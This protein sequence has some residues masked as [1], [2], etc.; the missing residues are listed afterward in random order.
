MA[1]DIPECPGQH[2]SA[3][4]NRIN[5]T[6]K[7]QGHS[8]DRVYVIRADGSECY[9]KCSCV[10]L[11]TPIA[12]PG[13]RWRRIQEVMVGDQVMTAEP[14]GH[15]W[16]P[17]TV[18]FSDGTK[19][20]GN[21]VP[22]TI[23]VKTEN[24]IE[25]VVTANHPFLLS[26]GKLQQA[27]R[28]TRSDKLMDENFRPVGI[29]A[30][31]PTQYTGGIWNVS[32]TD[33][34]QPGEPLSNHLI[35]TA[36]II[37][38]DFYAQLYLVEGGLLAAP[39]M[40]TLEYERS[41]GVTSDLQFSSARSRT[42][43]DMSQVLPYKK[44]VPPDGAAPFLPDYMTS[45]VP[46]SLRPLDDTVTLET[47]KY[48][49]WLFK[50]I[51]S[52]VE[53]EVEQHWGDNTVNAYAWQEGGKKHVALLGG[54]IRHR[55]IKAEGLALVTAHEIGHHYGGPP[56]Y[57]NGL[58][59]GG[60]ADYWGAWRAM[61]E[62][63]PGG[64]YF[65]QM[66][67]AIDQLDDLFSNG[68]LMGAS[69]AHQRQIFEASR[70]CSHPPAP[71]RKE[72]YLAAMRLDPKPD[73]ASLIS[74]IGTIGSEPPDYGIDYGCCSG[75][76]AAD[77]QSVVF[78]GYTLS[79]LPADREVPKCTN[80]LCLR[81]QAQISQICKQIGWEPGTKI[82]VMEPDNKPCWCTCH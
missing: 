14:A 25:L 16:T 52:E 24:G 42:G 73:C 47:A 57:S 68:L 46:G 32:T 55:A 64:E 66:R 63:A 71:C 45:A 28:L 58:S 36:G 34:D 7:A 27:I 56:T 65:Q 39:A 69:P 22:G 23:Y 33:S 51:Y 79:L 5:E 67:P 1:D 4:S 15:T 18:K 80:E 82:L 70:G 8:G 13:S 50:R 54:L 75:N 62:V 19:G 53:I 6:C 9:C 10:A 12:V 31:G 35:N 20:D 40:G 60:Q 78:N 72:T 11:N 38:G 21:Q 26:T 49:A 61:R 37:S 44:F 2:C 3:I 48:V 74:R 17:R 29:L 30:I 41:N 76:T 81:L 77:K 59:C 43:I